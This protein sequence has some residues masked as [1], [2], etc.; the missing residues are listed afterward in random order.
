MQLL[1]INL[2]FVNT[3]ISHASSLDGTN[4][5]G[6]WVNMQELFMPRYGVGV[7]TVDEKIYALGGYGEEGFCDWV[8]LYD[9]E[10]N[11]WEPISQIPT[12]RYG[13]GIIS[14]EKKIYVI[15]G[16]TKELGDLNSVEV[17]DTELNSWESKAD[18]PT[19]K[20]RF[21]IAVVD[22]IIYTIGGYNGEMGA[23]N[24]VEAYQPETNSWSVRKR[25]PSPRSRLMAAQANGKI[26]AMG[27]YYTDNLSI[28]E[29][30]NPATDSWSYKGELPIP[31]SSFQVVELNNV[32]FVLGGYSG[33]ALDMVDVYIPAQN[34]FYS[35]KS[36]MTERYDFGAV[37]IKDKLY[38][39]GGTNEAYPLD[40][41]EL[42]ILIKPDPPQNVA[43][44][45]V[46]N[47]VQI[48]WS[49]VPNITGYDIEVDGEI[50]DVGLATQYQHIEP[51]K[52]QQH[53]YRVRAK[54]IAGAGKWSTVQ[55]TIVWHDT[56]SAICFSIDNWITKNSLN[57]E[58][59]ITLKGNNISDMY[60]I[61]LELVYDTDDIKIN[62]EAF[63]NLIWSTE[64]NVFFEA[65]NNSQ[66]GKIDLIVS[67]MGE[68][69][70]KDGMFDIASFKLNLTT[71]NIT[72]L[73]INRIK[74]V[75]ATGNYIELSEYNDL[76]LRVLTE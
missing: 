55:N 41:V 4:I 60:T 43:V 48:L 67:K 52:N 51:V 11:T 1:I 40:S 3:N 29:E 10:M 39:V 21:G 73:E 37:L 14:L 70:G 53:V 63:E 17:Y 7:V 62:S 13:A 44:S 8:E 28:I 24:T 49:E 22:N 61:Y 15:G 74:L 36:M 56:Q 66:E 46:N 65:Q 26:Y 64:S 19:A 72:K 25:M 69:E 71:L 75:D 5:V 34:A 31:K 12:P 54:N 32:I 47:A 2:T 38:I 35:Q 76:S 59:G 6:N 20:S 45:E 33:N 57:E 30:Y 16:Y 58:M 27:G 9:P 23:L 50:I 18:M 42:S 68:S